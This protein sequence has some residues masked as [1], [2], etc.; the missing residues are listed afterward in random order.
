[1]ARMATNPNYEP[2]CRVPCEDFV[3]VLD[4]NGGGA[5]VPAIATN[6]DREGVI[7]T[8]GV[9]DTA[10]GTITVKLRHRY[11]AI[12]VRGVNVGD[13]AGNLVA[14]GVADT[15]VDPNTITIYIYDTDATAALADTTDLITVSARGYFN[16]QGT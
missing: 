5:G 7:A 8:S 16:A 9:A 4:G 12:A 1:M 11:A 3:F 14:T 2:R 10:T 6:G 15:T 13:P